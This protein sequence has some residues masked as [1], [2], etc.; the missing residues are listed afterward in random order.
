MRAILTLTACVVLSACSSGE[1][2]F[3]TPIDARAGAQ[4]NDGT[5]GQATMD[6]HLAMT[7]RYRVNLNNR[8]NAEVPTMVTFPFNS[9]ALSPEA[10]A[11]LRA[12]AQWINQFP[13]VKFRV[14]GHTDL[15]GGNAYNRRLGLRRAQAVVLYLASQGVDR[16]RLD[17]VVS[18]GETQPLIVTQGR[19]R[20]NRRTVTEVQGFDGRHPNIMDGNYAAVVFR[21]YVESGTYES[22]LNPPEAELTVPED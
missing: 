16:K 10:R 9:T 3:T 19:E 1:D 17:A 6:N 12:Q 8:F 7:G 21:E 4:L 20:R 15:V 11:A 22:R 2:L 14:Y 5:F 13:E 18:L